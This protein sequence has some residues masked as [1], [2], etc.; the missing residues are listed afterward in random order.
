MNIIHK[1]KMTKVI[2]FTTGGDEVEQT[3][4]GSKCGRPTL[5]CGGYWAFLAEM[6]PRAMWRRYRLQEV[7][8]MD[9]RGRPTT[10]WLPDRPFVLPNFRFGQGTDST[11]L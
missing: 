6:L 4:T 3:R 7:S 2:V 5:N 11:P 9:I 8:C 10:C 1:L